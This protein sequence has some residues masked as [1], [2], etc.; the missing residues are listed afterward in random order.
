[1]HLD[2]RNDMNDYTR[3]ATLAG[4][5]V[6]RLQGEGHPNNLV[7]P[8]DTSYD[9]VVVVEHPSRR[10]SDRIVLGAYGVYRQKS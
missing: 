10:S 3:A 9:V 7:P 1:M 8:T 5:I 2:F 4:Q 6:K